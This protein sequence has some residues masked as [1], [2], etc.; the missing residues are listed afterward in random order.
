MLVNQPVNQLDQYQTRMTIHATLRWS[1]L[2][3]GLSFQINRA[4]SILSD[5]WCHMKLAMSGQEDIVEI[6]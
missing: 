5:A 6:N 4:A 3:G 1:L 2:Q